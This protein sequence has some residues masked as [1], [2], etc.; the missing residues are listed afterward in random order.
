MYGK[1]FRPFLSGGITHLVKVTQINCKLLDYERYN[2][3]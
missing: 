2:D 1:P 3:K